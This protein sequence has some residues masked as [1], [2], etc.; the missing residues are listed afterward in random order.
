MSAILSIIAG[1]IGANLAA[2]H[3]PKVSVQGLMNLLL[4]VLGGAGI[5]ALLWLSTVIVPS[6]P[7]VLLIISLGIVGGAVMTFGA[8]FALKQKNRMAGF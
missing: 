1:V 5:W 3:W 6:L 7:G 8:A 4:G 2:E